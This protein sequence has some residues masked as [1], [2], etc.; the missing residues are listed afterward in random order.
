MNSN[1]ILYPI[2]FMFLL[3]I[4]TVIRNLFCRILLFTQ[5]KVKISDLK[6]VRLEAFPEKAVY[7]TK[8]I[9]NL[10]EM[11]V[12]F[13]VI[14]LIA[15]TK[16]FTDP[17]FISLAWIYVILRSVH[18]LIHTT[19]NNLLHRVIPFVLSNVVLVCMWILFYSTYI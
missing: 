5:K 9:S 8:N 19:Y 7:L 15:L 2:F 13:F 12:L 11:P 1:S 16:E 3:I 18:T 10:Y 4:V 6:E 14:C 17:I